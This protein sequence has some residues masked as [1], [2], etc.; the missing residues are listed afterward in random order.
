MGVMDAV[1]ALL[2]VGNNDGRRRAV[3]VAPDHHPGISIISESP[4]L[5]TTKRERGGRT[6][7]DS[8]ETDGGSISTAFAAAG[9]NSDAGIEDEGPSGEAGG[10]SESE[11]E[12]GSEGDN[13]DLW[14]DGVGESRWGGDTRYLLTEALGA[15]CASVSA[16]DRLA[17]APEGS[18]AERA[19]EAEFNWEEL[20]R[21]I[22]RDRLNVEIEASR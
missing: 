16:Y 8:L 14:R 6:A 21:R 9:A 13:D 11:V 5:S 10:L 3:D 19:K 7:L 22:A 18:I 20:Q 4:P 1:R 15:W 17:R 2:N 12:V